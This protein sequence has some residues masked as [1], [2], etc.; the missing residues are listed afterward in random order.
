MATAMNAALLAPPRESLG[1]EPKVDPPPLWNPDAA[2][3]WS[4]FITPV[5]GSALVLK[6]WQSIG[7]ESRAKTARVWLMVSIIATLCY[8]FLPFLGLCYIVIWYFAWQRK[9]T[10][11][12]KER[13]GKDYPRK[14]WSVPLLLGIG[15]FMVFAIVFGWLGTL[16]ATA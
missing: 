9:Q 10:K 6:N 4:L 7:D 11:Y 1:T 14:S 15:G 13:W 12:I 8:M 5:F 2:G 16:S 3:I